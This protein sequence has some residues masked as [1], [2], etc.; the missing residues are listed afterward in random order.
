MVNPSE[1]QPAG[2]AQAQAPTS[3]Q[4]PTGLNLSG[5]DKAVN[6]KIYKQQWENVLFHRSSARQTERGL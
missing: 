5:K 6:W 2:T 1:E 3:I 4:P